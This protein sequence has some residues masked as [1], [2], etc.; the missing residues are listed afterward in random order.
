MPEGFYRDLVWNLRNGV[1]A[2]TRDGRVAVMNEIA[3]RVLGLKPRPS[4][5][6]R[7]FSEVLKDVPDVCRIVA[8]VFDIVA[9]SQSCRAPTQEHQ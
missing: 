4:D 8:G 3:Y 1:V 2:I 7:P 5:I 6:G 9:P